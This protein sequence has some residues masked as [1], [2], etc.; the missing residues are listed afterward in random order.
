MKH[1]I[2]IVQNKTLDSTEIWINNEFEVSYRSMIKIPKESIQWIET[3]LQYIY[4]T[5]HADGKRYIGAKI[6]ELLEI[7]R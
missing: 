2:K 3:M 5:A 4:E 7:K 1:V 6:C